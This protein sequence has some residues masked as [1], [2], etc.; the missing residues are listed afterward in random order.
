MSRGGYFVNLGWRYRDG[1]WMKDTAVI[2]KRGLEAFLNRALT[3][4]QRA[5]QLRPAAFLPYNHII[6][7]HGS[8][9]DNE[10]FWNAVDNGLERKPASFVLRANILFGLQPKWGSSIRQIN[11]FL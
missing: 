8:L 9:G 4:M 11:S 7:V 5:A 2:Q 10:A 1:K 3:D 6:G